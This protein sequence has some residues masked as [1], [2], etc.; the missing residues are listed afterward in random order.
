L[1]CARDNQPYVVPIYFVVGD[2]YLY[3]FALPGQKVD[4]MRENPKVCVEADTI[5]ARDD[6][7]SVVVVGRYQELSDAPHFQRDRALAQE[8]LQR[9]PMWWEPGAI[10]LDGRDGRDG[11]VPIVYRIAVDSLSGYR[12]VPASEDGGAAETRRKHEPSP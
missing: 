7:T 9:R 12:G 4:W 8:L 1:A 11:Y 2:R 5:G 3:S 6:W 10:S